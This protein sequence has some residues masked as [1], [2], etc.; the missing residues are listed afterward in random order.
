RVLFRSLDVALRFDVI[1]GYDA[2]AH[3]EY[4]DLI[5]KGS[6]PRVGEVIT[7]A[8]HH[9]PLFYVL[10]V[11]LEK[12]GLGK[13]GGLLISFVAGVVR[14]VLADRVFRR[15]APTAPKYALVFAN[16]I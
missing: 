15:L 5:A 9:P 10:A 8:G 16:A 14:L 12:I 6:M 4:S 13:D 7:W 11:A 3:F 1:N 2:L